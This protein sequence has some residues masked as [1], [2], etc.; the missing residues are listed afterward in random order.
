[1]TF[2]YISAPEN[3]GQI[4]FRILSTLIARPLARTAVTPNQVTLLRGG[5]VM[6][7]LYFFSLGGAGNLLW[8]AMLFYL[9]EILDHVDGDLARLT[10]RKSAVGPLLEQFIDTWSARPSN[11][12]GF[13]IALGIYRQSGGDVTGF[14]LFGLTALGRMLWLEYRDYFGWERAVSSVSSEDKKKGYSAVFR[15]GSWREGVR[16]LAEIL[17]TWNNTFLLLAALFYVPVGAV[18]A[19]DPMIAAFSVVALV[20]N[21]PWIAIVIR[22]FS[23]ALNRDKNRISGIQ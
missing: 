15:A 10:N 20:N 12:F 16:N 3:A 11:I 8:A 9:F 4:P 7:A 18:I 22:G 14:V 5:I 21:I 1:M 17:Y 23:I 6:V 19:V 13:C 2:S